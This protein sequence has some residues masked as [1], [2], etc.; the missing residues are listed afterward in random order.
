MKTR[1]AQARLARQ[2]ADGLFVCG[3]VGTGKS[4]LAQ[5]VSGEIGVPCVMLKNFRSNMSARRKG[6]SN[7]C[8]QCCARW[9]RV[10]VV[11]EAD[12]ALGGATDGDSGTSSRVFG[13]IASQMGDTHI[14]AGS[15]GC[16]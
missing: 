11:D 7:A 16:C 3:P 10:V 8:C 6:T 4:F 5:C 1:R 12:A 14:A 2:S 13:M 9:D 15:S